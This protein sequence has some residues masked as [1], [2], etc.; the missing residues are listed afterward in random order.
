MPILRVNLTRHGIRIAGRREGDPAGVSILEHHLASLP[1]GAPVIAMIHGYK[2]SPSMAAHTPHRHILS[3]RPSSRDRRAVSWPR[4]LGFGRGDA[5][6]GLCIAVGWEARGT[7]WQAYR[8]AYRAG[9]ALADLITRVRAIRPGP[10]NAICHSLGARV[11]LSALAHLEPGDLGRAVLLSG[12]E[13]A[14]R[15]AKAL[16]TPAG[17]AAEVVNVAS[18]ENDVFDALLWLFLR[19]WPGSCAAL[20]RGLPGGHPNWLDVRIDDADVRR[21]LATLGL[22]LPPPARRVCH[23]SG[24]LR[25]GM[26]A[27]HRALLRSPGHMPLPVL[28]G[29]L[30]RATEGSRDP[31]LSGM[32]GWI[33]QACSA[34]EAG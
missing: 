26:F 6:E 22:R 1:P 21:G 20:G 24:Y 18:R 7:I 15:A 2:F 11:V 13:F 29:A 9:V 5:A 28:R 23:W 27:L 3:A 34:A 30:D 33:N 32:D 17:R 25:P 16:D 8:E 12:A 4:H 31:G 14:D 10:V 19:P